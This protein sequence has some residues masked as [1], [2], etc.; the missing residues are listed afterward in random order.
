[1]KYK[2][3]KIK[4]FKGI[5]NLEFDLEGKN[6][7]S[8]VFTLVG[9]NE[10]GKTTILEALSFFYDNVNSEKELTITKSIFDDV[11]DLI[12]KSKKGLFNESI[13]VSAVV[14]FE[15]QDKEE[16]HKFLSSNGFV[17][18]DIIDEVVI[19][20]NLIFKD[21][22]YVNKKRSWTASI[23]KVKT[24]GKGK[25]SKKCLSDVDDGK[26]KDLV[27]YIENNLLPAIIYYPNFLFDFPDQIF[28]EKSE[29][30]SKEQVFYR[31]VLQDI[32]SS[33]DKDLLLKEHIVDRYKKSLPKDIDATESVVNKMSGQ[34]TRF[35]TQSKMNVFNKLLENKGV[36][37]KYPKSNDEGKIY[38]EIKLKS[39]D[40]EYF[41]RERS[42]GFRW[43]LTY[44]LFTQ[45]RVFRNGAKKLIFL[46]DEP[47]S[48]LHQTGQHRLLDALSEL[49]SNINAY[50]IYSTHSHH[51]INPKWL[52]TTYIVKNNAMDYENESEYNSQMT[53]ISI[54]RYRTFVSNNP[55]Q[56]NF[57]QPILDVLEYRPSNLENIPNVVMLEGKNDFYT[58]E[59]INKILK[60]GSKFNFIP[61]MGSGK[62]DTVIQLYYAWGRNFLILL[63]SD[64]AGIKEKK[65]Y[66]EKFGS[67]V[68]DKVFT[69]DDINSKWI[70]KDME[71]IFE[72][73]DSLSIQKSIYPLDTKV[74]KT[75]LNLAIQ[76]LLINS[77]SLE[78]TSQTSKNFE[79]LF[80][81]FDKKLQNNET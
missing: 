61:G 45:F 2:K 37:I 58:L 81:F 69:F 34:V 70:K 74:N 35:L 77:T 78:I 1:M 31:A 10:S 42:L 20:V 4:N 68:K 47:A 5:Q 9:L 32:L 60:L 21:S 40:D 24:E 26:W 16:I 51:L 49:T 75:K 66:N 80:D 23:V 30:E 53:N 13:S 52:E 73:G 44:L 19:K 59:Y 63:D 71:D 62:L 46:F 67:I 29:N 28:L 64:D 12:P 55:S 11:H 50:V 25:A 48:N 3:F 33:I 65:R 76:E 72:G 56:I 36:L 14:Q 15:D 6:P 18:S 41:I 17:S 79:L 27:L 43:F 8:K 39:G 22:N 54:V 57:F 7:I 38:L